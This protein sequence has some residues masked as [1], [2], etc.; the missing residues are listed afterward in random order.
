MTETNGVGAQVR[1]LRQNRGLSQEEL[2]EKAGV[3]LKTLC[4]VE[5]DETSPRLD[6][7]H[8]LARALGVRTAELLQPGSTADLE[9]RDAEDMMLI[10]IRSVL[11]PARGTTYEDVD[12]PSLDELT[13]QAVGLRQMHDDGRNTSLVQV[14]PGIIR[15]ARAAVRQYQGQDRDKA[16]EVLAVAYRES[17]HA[18]AQ[19]GREDLAG[20]A[21]TLA[22]D[23]A[24]ESG[25]VL[26]AGHC[27][28][29]TAWVYLRQR[30][31]EDAVRHC[32]T[33]ADEIEPRS[34]R[35]TSTLHLATWGNLLLMASAAAVRNNQPETA[36][37]LLRAASA[38][39]ELQDNDP[40]EESRLFSLSLVPAK[41]RMM[42]VEHAVIAFRPGEA[43]QLRRTIPED[44]PGVGVIARSRFLLDVANAYYMQGRPGHA[45]TVLSKLKRTRPGWLKHQR[46]AKD[47]T[48]QIV[49]AR[50]RRLPND[51]VDLAEF[52]GV[53][54]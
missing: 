41:V 20:H 29:S 38:A 19:L 5:R 24:E 16:L 4:G 44:A 12:P 13:R 45:V 15:S 22:A 30:R 40:P 9:D 10:G 11:M 39:A 23:A 46:Y 54:V 43:L 33:V 50:A 36:R 51:L 25:N 37:E 14:A 49:E 32:V 52:L 26:L 47:L 17:A 31:L 18:L 6:T 34:M 2:A 7:L 48:R 28:Y 42:A 1:R 3:N 27:V 21:L 35:R 53:A 8:K